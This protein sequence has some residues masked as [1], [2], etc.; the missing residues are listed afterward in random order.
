MPCSQVAVAAAEASRCWRGC[1]HHRRPPL[2]PP[3]LTTT[4]GPG[5]NKSWGSGTGASANGTHRPASKACKMWSGSIT[6]QLPRP[7]LDCERTRLLQGT[8]P[9]PDQGQQALGQPTATPPNGAPNGERS[10]IRTPY[11]PFDR[12]LQLGFAATTAVDRHLP[13]GAA[14]ATPSSC[15]GAR[16]D[17]QVIHRGPPTRVGPIA[18]ALRGHQPPTAAPANQTAT[19]AATAPAKLLRWSDPTRHWHPTAAW[20]YGEDVREAV[21]TNVVHVPM[22][23]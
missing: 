5:G 21:P 22:L 20:R 17:A 15:H 16:V 19:P 3:L 9:A 13:Q 7:A 12:E 8:I 23:L 14:P 2:L 4:P 6:L 18:R 11:S 1:K 10:R